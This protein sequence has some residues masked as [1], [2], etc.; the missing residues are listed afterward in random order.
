[1][2]ENAEKEHYL[3]AVFDD[4]RNEGSF[5]GFEGRQITIVIVM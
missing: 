4:S 1:M 2:A 3:P 5:N